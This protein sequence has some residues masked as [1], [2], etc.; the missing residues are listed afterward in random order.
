MEDYV[1][2][3]SGGK[4][5]NWWCAICGEKN[6]WKQPNRLLVQ[7]GESVNQA[8]VFKAHAHA[9]GLIQNIVTNLC[10]LAGR[11]SWRVKKI[12]TS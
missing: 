1:W 7:P 3:V 4:H 5:T 10:E 8:K 11:V 12:H 2:W 9:D 6:D